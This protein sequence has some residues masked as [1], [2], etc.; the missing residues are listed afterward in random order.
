M[1]RDLV[2]AADNAVFGYPELKA[3]LCRHGRGPGPGAA[4][5]AQAGLRATD[6]LRERRRRASTGSR[7]DQPVVLRDDLLSEARRMSEQ[8]AA[9]DHDGLWMTKRTIQRAASMSTT[10]ALELAPGASLVMRLHG[11]RGGS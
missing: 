7:H 3:G 9:S 1:S 8:L 10:E 4:D 2:V 6:P 5:R 11:Q